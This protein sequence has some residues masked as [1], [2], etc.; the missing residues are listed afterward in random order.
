MMFALEYRAMFFG[1]RA[2][3]NRL[4]SIAAV[5]GSVGKLKILAQ[6]SLAKPGKCNLEG[7][8]PTLEQ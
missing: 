6:L 2:W 8:T 7:L 4:G 5:G 1:Q 3:Y